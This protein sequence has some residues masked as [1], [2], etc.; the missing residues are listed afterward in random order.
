MPDS[1]LKPLLKINSS[2]LEKL[3]TAEYQIVLMDVQ[4]PIMDGYETIRQIRQRPALSTLPILA[5]TA[6]AMKDDRQKCLEAGAND[7]LPKPVNVDRLFS[8]LRVWLYQ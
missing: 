6:K 7:Y 2:A 3:K 1:I 5:L 4:M 8:M